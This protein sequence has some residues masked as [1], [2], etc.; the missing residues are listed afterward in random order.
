MSAIH[1]DSLSFSYSSA[2][3]ILGD[4]SCSLG[5]GWTGVVGAN[6]SGK[7]TL[8]RLIDGTLSADSGALGLDPTNALVVHCP[9]TADTVDSN[10][11]RLAEAWDGE[12]HAWLGRLALRPDDLERWPTMSPG[13]RKRWQIGGALYQD[14]DILLLD[15]PTNHLDVEARDMLIVALNRFRGAGVVVSHDRT[16]LNGLCRR[17]LRIENGA[18][19]LWQ[20]SYEVARAAWEER[21]QA[22]LEGYQRVRAEQRKVERRLAD[23][24]RASATKAARHKRQ[25]RTA[26]IKDRDARSMEKKGRFEGG[27]RQGSHEISLLRDE[28]ERLDAAAAGFDIRRSL[29]GELFFDFEPARRRRRLLAH[30]GPIEVAGTTL[31]TKANVEVERNDRVLLVGPNGAGK[32]TL[33][34]ALLDRS[35]LDPDRILYLPQELTVEQTRELLAEVRALDAVAR[36]RVLGMVALLGSDPERIL[37]TDTPSPG[38]ARKLLI[39]S[40]LGRGAWILLLDEPTNHLDLPSIERLERA[41][42]A[43]PGAVVV[44][45]HDEAFG[46]ETTHTVWHLEGGVLQVLSAL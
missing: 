10:I 21:D 7:T 46:R 20:G 1:L 8:L 4:A 18:T 27:Q 15:E 42:I 29:G 9:Q 32:T 33:L 2:I 23:K 30:E 34:Q 17:I 12:A 16:V 22:Q 24:R 39:A 35:T 6:G 44:I 45:T 19:V 14:P 11:N 41:L 31:I 13:E 40:G 25:L 43:Y 26:G 3:P 36:G 28:A 38:E 37:A 5:D